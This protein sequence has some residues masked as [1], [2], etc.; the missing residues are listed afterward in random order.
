VSAPAQHRHGSARRRTFT[1]DEIAA[2]RAKCP[3]KRHGTVNAYDYDK[4]RCCDARE[5]HRLARKRHRALIAEA[6]GGSGRNFVDSTGTRRRAEALIC[7]GWSFEELSRRIGTSRY[8]VGK[9]YNSVSR[10][11]SVHSSSAARMAALYEKLRGT[12]GHSAHALGRAR[13]DNLAPWWAWHRKDIDDPK[14]KPWHYG[15]DVEQVNVDRVLA[16]ARGRALGM[17]LPQLNHDETAL[18]VATIITS[19]KYPSGTL[20]RIFTMGNPDGDTLEDEAGKDYAEKLCARG[21]V[22][23]RALNQSAHYFVVR[24]V[25]LDPPMRALEEQWRAGV[26]A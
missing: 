26:A 3:A 21:G 15:Y 24:R 11:G 2:D 20:R 8:S 17:D 14:V 7:D 1:A 19:W 25:A 9:W 16:A 5:D 4:C 22:S 23:R 18:V 10:S 6:P 12:P 13:R